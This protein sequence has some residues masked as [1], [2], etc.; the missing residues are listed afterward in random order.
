MVIAT[1]SMLADKV[2]F[3]GRNLQG[4]T[5]RGDGFLPSQRQIKTSELLEQEQYAIPSIYEN[6]LSKGSFSQ[7]WLCQS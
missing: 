3:C 1:C 4:C 6:R 2:G 5:V 7:Q